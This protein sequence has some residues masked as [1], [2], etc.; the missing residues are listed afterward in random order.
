MCTWTHFNSKPNLQRWSAFASRP[1]AVNLQDACHALSRSAKDG[2]A[3]ADASPQS[4]VEGVV[5]AA[6]AYFESDVATCK[7]SWCMPVS[8]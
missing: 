8:Q 3:A 2:A 6:E 7:V 1:T 5:A 4:V